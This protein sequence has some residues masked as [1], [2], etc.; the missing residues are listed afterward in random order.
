MAMLNEPLSKRKAAAFRISIQCFGAAEC[1]LAIENCPTFNP[2]GSGQLQ[3]WQFY[4]SFG[5]R[6][7]VVESVGVQ[8]PGAIQ[9]SKRRKNNLRNV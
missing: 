9:A 6:A 7:A 3:I 8:E 2:I 5:S 1:G 4:A